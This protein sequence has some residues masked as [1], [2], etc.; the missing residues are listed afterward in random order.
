MHPNQKQRAEP[1]RLVFMSVQ[2]SLFSFP[3]AVCIVLLP[4][5]N[6]LPLEFSNLGDVVGPKVKVHRGR[7]GREEAVRAALLR[8]GRRRL[9][10]RVGDAVASRVPST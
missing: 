6:S 9:P 7:C 1:F 10:G 3:L 2:R 5:L 8:R 4:A